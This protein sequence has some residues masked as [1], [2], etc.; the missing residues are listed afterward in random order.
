GLSEPLAALVL[1]CGTAL[2][3]LAVTKVAVVRFL[4]AQRIHLP[5]IGITLV[6]L[7]AAV[8]IG[9]LGAGKTAAHPVPAGP[10]TGASPAATVRTTAA[11]APGATAAAAGTPAATAAVQPSP[12]QAPVPSPVEAS[13]PATAVAAPP[14]AAPPSP[15]ATA[16]PAPPPLPGFA[17][18][19]GVW[20]A[21]GVTLSASS[22][23]SATLAFPVGRSCAG[24]PAP[25]DDPA[26]AGRVGGSA[27][28]MFAQAADPAATGTVTQSNAPATVPVGPTTL[29]LTHYDGFDIATLEAGALHMRLC[30]P[31]AL[32]QA[33]NL[34]TP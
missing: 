24:N 29:T 12:A 22:D 10:V 32:Q 18:F 23:G 2:V 17:P 15:S 3:L 20:S 5:A 30:S 31:L 9:S 13:S 19:V 7:L 33:A 4:P 34:C 28:L 11:A 21:G 6:V 1:I 26:I 8:F 27:A 25:C 16:T 14:T